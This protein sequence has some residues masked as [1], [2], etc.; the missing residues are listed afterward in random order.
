VVDILD[1]DGSWLE[2]AHDSDEFSPETGSFAINARSL[3]C[4]AQV[5]TREPS[6]HDVNGPNAVFARTSVLSV[7]AVELAHVSRAMPIR[8]VLVKNLP[9]EFVDLNLPSDRPTHAFS[10]KIESP[11]TGKQRAHRH[12]VSPVPVAIG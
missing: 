11:D 2:L 3:S 5:L 4:R 8:P 12:P 1:D 7:V 6:N 10:G 9:T